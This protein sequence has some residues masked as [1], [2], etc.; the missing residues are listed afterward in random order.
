ML[1]MASIL[2]FKT[3]S[4]IVMKQLFEKLQKEKEEKICLIQSSLKN[5]F[6]KKY[7]DICFKD[8]GKEGFYEI[9]YSVIQSLKKFNFEAIYIPTTGVRANNFGNIIEIC[10]NFS[11]KKLVFYNSNGES[12]VVTKKNCFIELLIKI[13]IGFIEMLYKK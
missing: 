6:Q 10:K 9:E 4:D 1:G 7:T 11:Y 8:I 2:I 13:Y 12:N 3:A 5:E